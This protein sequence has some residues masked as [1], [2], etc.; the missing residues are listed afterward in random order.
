MRIAIIGL[1]QSG[2][3]TLFDALTG[4]QD[5]PGAYAAPGSAQVGVAHVLDPRVAA[6]AEIVKPKKTTYAAI[7]F[8]D[9][10]GLFATERP[11]PDSAGA[12]R[13]A[14]GLVKVLRAFENPGVPPHKGAV[15]ALR[16][17]QE[18]DS[19]LFILDL[20]ILERRIERL[21]LSVKKPT[22]RQEGEKVELALLE[23]CHAHLQAHG[24]LSRLA[25][26]EEE[27]KA[28][29]CFCFLTQKPSAIVVNIGEKQIGDA[30]PVACLGQRHEPTLAVAAALEKELLALE[31]A[32]R[33]PF[34]QDLGLAELSAQKVLAAVL[35]AL[36]QITFFTAGE[37]E[38]RAWLIPRGATA[39]EAAGCVHTDLA[40][41][42][43][44]AEVI[45]AADFLQF[46]G[47]KDCRSHGKERLEGKD[48]VVQDGDVINIRFSV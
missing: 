40:R 33:A 24:S 1:P 14:D 43:I 3:T 15:D 32:E 23:R 45:S 5:D 7:E 17:L 42:F 47:W 27:E 25:V 39:V 18:I 11:D 35:S 38:L 46:G 31:P 2:K 48:Y 30:A 29:K 21:R 28:L 34:L 8:V 12:L 6:I 44:R 13:D 26:T 22:P 41:G 37:K 20:D 10:A 16:D 4:R 19:D 9:L 36:D